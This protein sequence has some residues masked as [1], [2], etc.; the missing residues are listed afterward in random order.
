MMLIQHHKASEYF[1]RAR[2]QFE[3][4]YAD[5]ADGAR[6]MALVQHPYIL[7]AAHRLRHFRRVIEMIATRPNVLFWTGSQIADWYKSAS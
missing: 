2:D 5:S 4:I 3:Q 7:G 6:V 1:D